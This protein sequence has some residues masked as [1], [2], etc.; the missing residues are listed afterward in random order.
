M[1]KEL[2]SRS[3]IAKE[4]FDRAQTKLLTIGWE[5]ELVE[6]C[7]EGPEEKINATEIAQ[8]AILTVSFAGF[9]NRVEN[10]A[11]PRLVTGHSMGEISALAVAEVF[12]FEDAVGLVAE[13][14]RLMKEAGEK[15]PGKMAAIIGLEVETVGRLCQILSEEHG[16]AHVTI[17]N[18]NSP[19]QIVISG[20]EEAIN[21]AQ[22]F[23][24]ELGA[25]LT[26]VLPVS[27]AAHSDLMIPTQEGMTI[28]LKS[29]SMQ[30]PTIDFVSPTT[31]KYEND[32][33][34]IRELLI[35]QL[36]SR[37]LWFETVRKMIG[38]GYNS[39]LEIGPG[40]TLTKLLKRIDKNVARNSLNL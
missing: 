18:N 2:L 21:N 20:D 24:K 33:Q 1:A 39:F 25:K 9:K 7:L 10:S 23:A 5:Q 36:T 34:A 26:V 38:D 32:P 12:T 31:G 37:V 40:E 22:N 3:L 35:A 29:I 8:P 27:I 28:A 4:V 13:R 30:P 19:G 14:G 11:L 6:L 15:R 16:N 17:A